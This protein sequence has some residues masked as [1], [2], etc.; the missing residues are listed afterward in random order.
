MQRL[1]NDAIY[2][3]QC[4]LPTGSELNLH[5]VS[6]E[7]ACYD[8][9][10]TTEATTEE[11]RSTVAIVRKALRESLWW[12]FAYATK[13]K[14]VEG[15]TPG[16]V[17]L[18]SKYLLLTVGLF[19][20]NSRFHHSTIRDTTT[21]LESHVNFKSHIRVSHVSRERK[22]GKVVL[23]AGRS[24]RHG[25]PTRKRDSRHYLTDLPSTWLGRFFEW[26]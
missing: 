26:S 14:C 23:I 20:F 8:T 4:C 15:M 3:N 13:L 18:A 17:E 19:L 1:L 25:L 10:T 5:V 21:R 11:P 24:G 7:H 6:L 12:M 9:V 22:K 16:R 2:G